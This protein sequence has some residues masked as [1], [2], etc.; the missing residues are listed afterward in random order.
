MLD[1][2]EIALYDHNPRQS[3]NPKFDVIKA[4][5]RAQGMD[6]PLVVTQRPGETAYMIGAGGNTR[7]KI[8]QA[9]Y[10]ETGEARFR[11]VSCIY[12]PWTGE[13]DVLVAHLRENDLRGDLTFLDKALAVK[14]LKRLIQEAQGEDS[15]TQTE[16]AEALSDRGYALSQG[17]ISQM[18]YAVERLLPVLPAA[19]RSGM[20]RPQVERIRQLERAVRALWLDRAVDTEDEFD[21]VFAE[22]CRRYDSPEWDIGNLRR[23]LEAEMAERAEVSIHTVSMVLEGYLA[24]RRDLDAGAHWLTETDDD[25]A[26]SD[27]EPVAATNAPESASS[28][29]PTDEADDGDI[30]RRRSAGSERRRRAPQRRRRLMATT[31]WLP[32]ITPT[33]CKPM[34]LRLRQRRGSSRWISNHYAPVP[35]HWR[36]DWP[37]VTA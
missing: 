17:L 15:V 13:T 22:L 7:L 24:G 34:T 37:S 35:G 19:L 29:P 9:L 10:E 25:D 28:P 3:A 26:T 5:I 4:S 8:L 36:A 11:D 2:G 16:L 6:Q 1:V 14:A 12:R 21:E 18:A 20:G 23:A 31:T 33:R 27:A 32:K 30:T